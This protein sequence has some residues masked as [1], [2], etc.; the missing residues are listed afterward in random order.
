[1][2]KAK[3]NRAKQVDFKIISHR[4]SYIQYF[5][6]YLCSEKLIEYILL[7]KVTGGAEKVKLT[8]KV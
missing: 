8:F 4:K 5:C 7:E 3:T 2:E 6:Y 1:M